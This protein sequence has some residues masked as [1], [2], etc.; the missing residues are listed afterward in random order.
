MARPTDW[1]PAADGQGATRTSNK[2]NTVHRQSTPAG[3]VEHINRKDGSTV[4]TT[5]PTTDPKNPK[6]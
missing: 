3:T 2:G 4:R 5:Q 6:R 1:K